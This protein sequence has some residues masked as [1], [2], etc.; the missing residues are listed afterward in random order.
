VSK[1]LVDWL[2]ALIPI[3]F[4]I[5]LVIPIIIATD[6]YSAN[7]K[8]YNPD[9]HSH[10]ADRETAVHNHIGGKHPTAY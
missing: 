4:L 7:R 9:L 1:L 3:T 8:L 10:L 5:L 2:N 6:I